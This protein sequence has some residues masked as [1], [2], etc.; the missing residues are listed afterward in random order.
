MVERDVE[1]EGKN[2]EREDWGIV[3]KIL[4]FWYG[5]FILYEIVN[6]RI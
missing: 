2:G 1:E 6:I 3:R 4:S 5:Y